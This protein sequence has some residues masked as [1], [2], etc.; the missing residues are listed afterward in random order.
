[1]DEESIKVPMVTRVSEKEPSV[2]P[3]PHNQILQAR[4]QP[5]TKG[6]MSFGPYGM[7][8]PGLVKTFI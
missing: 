5:K 7:I 3:Q 6:G 2:L 8:P 1:M 4:A